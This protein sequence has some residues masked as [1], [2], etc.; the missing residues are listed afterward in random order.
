MKSGANILLRGIIAVCFLVFYSGN[1]QADQCEKPLT[2]QHVQ[3]AEEELLIGLLRVNG[4][5]VSSGFDIFPYD[6]SFLVPLQ[7]LKDLLLFDWEINQQNHTFS[8]IPNQNHTHYCDFD[9]AFN[10]QTSAQGFYWSQDDFDMYIDIR[11]LPFLI[12]GSATFSYEIQQLQILTE[13]S[14]PGLQADAS[15]KI[16]SFQAYQPVLPDK[17]INDQYWAVTPPLMNYRLTTNYDQKLAESRTNFS[18]NGFFDLA[19]HATE[20]R[21]NRTDSNSQQFLRLSKNLDLSDGNSS[22]RL[23]RYELGDL[24]LQSDE[25]ISRAKQATGIS[26]FNFDP[27]FSNSF[28]QVTIDETVLPG[29]R[30]QL[31]RNGQFIEELFS[32]D[33]NQVVF[34]NVD[35][36]YGSNLFEIKLYGP[37]GQQEVRTQTINVGNDQL[38]PG[39]INYRFSAS[40]ASARTI[41]SNQNENLYDKNL[42][43]LFAY[44][45][46]SNITLETSINLLEGLGERQNYLSSALYV[47]FDAA[48]IK[49]QF[50]KDLDRG[51]ALFTGVN[52]NLGRQ[53]KANL[54]SRYFTDFSSDAYPQSRGTKSETRLRLNGRTD[55]LDGMGWNF[56]ALHRTFTTRDATSIVNLG[57]N[58][59]LLGG[60]F[61]TSLTYNSSSEEDKLLHRLYWSKNFS[62][63][64]FSNSLEWLPDANGKVR[65]YYTNIRWP[66]RYQVF[67]ESRIEYR[68]NQD[69]KFSVSHRF[70]WRRD[71]FNL[72]F[73]ARVDDGGHWRVNFGISGDIEFNPFTRS[74]DFYR[75]R[76]SNVANVHAF[77]FLDNNRN[78]VFDDQDSALSDVTISGNQAWRNLQTNSNGGVQLATTL[79]RQALQ[80]DEASLP[81]PFMRPVED[82]VVVET[83][84]GGRNVV[85]LPV[86]TFTDIEGAIYVVKGQSSRGGAGI[87]LSLIDEKNEVVAQTK[88][89]I[90]G[91]FY[92]KGLAPGRYTLEVDSDYLL[93]NQLVVSNNPESILASE[94]GDALR[95]NDILLTSDAI[96]T[97]PATTVTT[98]D[99]ETADVERQKTPFYVQLGAFKKPRS[100]IEVVKH[101]T[102]DQFDLKIYRNHKTSLSHVV[103]G[104]YA[105]FDEAKKAIELVQKQGYFKDAFVSNRHRYGQQGWQLEYALLNLD[106]HITRSKEEVEAADDTSYFCMLASYHSMTS[107]DSSILN[108]MLSVLVSRRE[109]AG[110]QYNSLFFG[111][112]KNSSECS[113]NSG[114]QD[115]FRQSSFPIK[116]EHLKHQTQ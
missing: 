99:L 96:A 53:L 76:G 69:D 16:P 19:K 111:P 116:T 45:L 29:W 84:R 57:V 46:N 114:Y 11:A 2:W 40:D 27:N 61:S 103:I 113:Q 10:T 37:E 110:V 89:E 115:L 59:N 28:S 38:T 83:H 78:N 33:T 25:L 97:Q 86:V 79:R 58:K 66:Q 108:G 100:I 34:E 20:L 64:Q 104:G 49:T 5:P 30:A 17:V 75:P 65:N 14:V 48:T 13:T 102:A 68:A 95:L 87:Q 72:Q 56:S 94:L 67:N 77:A 31:F 36:F 93:N 71:Q 6:N 12:G 74:I 43:A 85:E 41:D 109:V 1:I 88:T 15:V 51:S 3:L 92:V 62:G 82:L 50:V 52:A 7:S 63:W 91:Y 60:T 47:S 81:D 54:T 90:D 39:K 101:L 4:T 80:I 98:S 32:D 44:G 9:I 8:T 55:W 70:N 105:T 21:F 106:E 22:E 24:Q 107:I 26:I 35:T 18:V 112:V 73:G 42:S 23:L